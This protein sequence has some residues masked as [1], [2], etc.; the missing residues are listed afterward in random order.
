MVGGPE[1]DPLTAWQDCYSMEPKERIQIKDAKSEIQRAWAVWDG[2]KTAE[3]SMLLFFGWLSQHRPYF[4][5][6][7]GREDPWRKGYGWLVEYERKQQ[8]SAHHR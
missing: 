3:D 5:T 1:N 2:D 8:N 7:R 4:L 6:F